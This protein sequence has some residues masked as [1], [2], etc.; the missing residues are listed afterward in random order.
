MTKAILN[1]KTVTLE[2]QPANLL[3]LVAAIEQDHLPEDWIVVEVSVNGTKIEGFTHPDGSLIPYDAGGEV[4]ITAKSR[5]ELLI[6]ILVRFEGYLGGII[7]GIEQII[8]LYRS[9]E[10]EE[11]S[12][13][14]RDAIDGIRVLIELIQN[15][16]ETGMIGDEALLPDGKGLADL[17]LGLKKTLEELVAAQTEGDSEKIADALEF[18]LVDQLI[19]WRQAMPEMRRIVEARQGD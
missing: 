17:A 1:G 7:P 9:G 2:G 3:E 13:S 18:E 15:I 4:S 10:L 8:A 12:K 11:A 19:K 14:Y 16:R 6:G 5:S